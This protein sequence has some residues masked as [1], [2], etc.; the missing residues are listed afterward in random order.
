M[1][2]QKTSRY[3]RL[4]RQRNRLYNR[5]LRR[6]E[7]R[8][9]SLILQ[10]ERSGH[11]IIVARHEDIGVI[12]ISG[13]LAV[14]YFILRIAPTDQ[15]RTSALGLRKAGSGRYGQCVSIVPCTVPL[16]T[17][18]CCVDRTLPV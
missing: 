15:T 5:T 6:S 14:Y 18:S 10:R 2:V 13:R 1:P 8:I 12:N 16:Q 11:A 9:E 7:Y 3:E 17:S 4:H